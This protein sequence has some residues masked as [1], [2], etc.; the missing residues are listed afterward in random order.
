[1]PEQREKFLLSIDLLPLRVR[2]L[3]ATEMPVAAATIGDATAALATRAALLGRLAYV[4][5]EHDWDLAIVGGFMLEARRYCRRGE[6]ERLLCGS[7]ELAAVATIYL[8]EALGPDRV[9]CELFWAEDESRL[10]TV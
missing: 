5:A 7:P 6:V 8:D 4:L 9:P 10:V 3:A 1:M 2:G